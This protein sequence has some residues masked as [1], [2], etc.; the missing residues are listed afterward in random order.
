M[1][2]GTAN[3]LNLTDDPNLDTAQ[4]GLFIN[5]VVYGFFSTE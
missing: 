4:K 3:T 2:V 5:E 1:S